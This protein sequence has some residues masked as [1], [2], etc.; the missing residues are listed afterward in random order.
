MTRYADPCQRECPTVA[1]S[2]ASGKASGAAARGGGG[3]GG[4]GAMKPLSPS[5]AEIWAGPY[6][7]D[8]RVSWKTTVTLGCEATRSLRGGRVIS[9]G[10]SSA[11]RAS[12]AAAPPPPPARATTTTTTTMTA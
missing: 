9:R 2:S 6:D 11:R 5:W 10:T 8:K 7:F 4:G 12:Q 1:S 3:S